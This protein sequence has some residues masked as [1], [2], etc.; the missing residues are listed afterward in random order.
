M[1]LI[2]YL[3]LSFNLVCSLPAVARNPMNIHTILDSIS[4]SNPSLKMY[5]AEVRSMDEAVKRC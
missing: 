1:K 3:L 4:A 2:W 5:D